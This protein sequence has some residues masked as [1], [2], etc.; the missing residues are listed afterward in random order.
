VCKCKSE[1]WKKKIDHRAP[2]I[3]RSLM[4]DRVGKEK[5]KTEVA[6]KL[7]MGRDRVAGFCKTT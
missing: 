1:M 7:Y 5:Q 6:T 4:R 2:R 3:G